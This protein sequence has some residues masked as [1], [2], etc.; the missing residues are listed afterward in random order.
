EGGG[1]EGG[2]DGHGGSGG[3]R[4]D[5]AHWTTAID[6]SA[7]RGQ[8][9]LGFAL[10]EFDTPVER[11]GFEDVRGLRLLGVAGFIDPP[12]DEAIAAVADC[13]SA[14]IR[15]KMITGDHARTAAAIATQLGLGEPRVITGAELDQVDD[16]AL[17]ALAAQTTVFARTSPEHKLRIVRA[18]QRD[19]AIVAMTGDGVNDAPSLKQADVGIAMGRK[20][21]EAAKQASAMVLADDNFASIVAAVSEGRTVYDNIRK[22]IAWT[23]PTNG[24]EVLAIIVGILAGVTL[25]M[26]PAQI[27]WINMILT[28]TLGLVFAFEPAEPGVMQRPPR[29]AHAPLLSRFM[30]W[31][32]A[33]VSVLFVIG[34]FAVFS[35]SLSRGHDVET[36]RTL[37]VNTIVVLEIFYLF[38]VRYLHVSSFSWRG[39]AGTPPVLLAITV[40]VLAQLAYTYAPP[41][42][43]LFESRP[44]SLLDGAVAIAAGV[45]MM[46]V[47]EVEKAIVRRVAGPLTSL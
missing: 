12:R 25:P 28:V 18:L 40:V 23:L 33:F 41:M 2:G 46:L 47:L 22:V 42:Q 26:T 10:R 38:N 3:G 5:D 31:R 35:W 20:G 19:G 24:G 44:L 8:R 30:V 36:A 1:G 21:T 16:A 14:G 39:A 7:G 9:V 15:V 34:V 17:D 32:I 43:Q 6:E 37:V 29:P 27:L 11:I 4:A 13:R 45:V